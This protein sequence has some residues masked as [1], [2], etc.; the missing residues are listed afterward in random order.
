[1]FPWL[2]RSLL[3]LWRKPFRT[4]LV[5]FFLALVVGLFTVMATINR[6]ATRQF[7]ELEGALE[8]TVDIRPIG[9]LGL[10]G[11]R[12]KPLPFKLE[13]EIRETSADLRVDPY[14][15]KRV[16]REDRVEFFVGARPGSPLLAVGDPEPMDSRVIAGRTFLADESNKFVAVIG[17][18]LARKYGIMPQNFEESSTIGINGRTWQVIG[19]FDGG[20]GFTN[21]QAF[22]P[23]ETMQRAFSSEGLSRIVVRAL[24]TRRAWKFAEKMREQLVGQAD[25]V[26]N[27]PAVLLAQASLA[28]ISGTT[29]MGAAL[30]FV[31]GALVVMGAMMLAFRDQ[32]REIGIEKALGASNA[33]IA[34][35]LL[36]ES[37]LLSFLGSFGGLGIAWIGLSIYARSW[38]S[39]KFGLVQAPLSP[40]T[41]AVIL[42]VSLALGALGS[43]YPVARSRRLDPVEILREE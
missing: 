30:F 27:Q 31:A 41:L 9:S 18:D 7:A 23:F 24:S 37:L 28:G 11:R 25:V 38:T 39:I 34:R 12:S 43:L 5:T 19:L 17:I 22:L 29:G 40:L 13:E 4:L 32:R 36:T 21:I 8:T 14:L 26:T 20:N 1:M 6:L 35:R 33:V 3:N 16:L 2:K 10:G 15:I 42:L